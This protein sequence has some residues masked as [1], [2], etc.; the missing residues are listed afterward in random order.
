MPGDQPLAVAISINFAPNRIFFRSESHGNPPVWLD[1]QDRV[2]SAHDLRWT[3]DGQFLLFTWKLPGK[4]EIYALPIAERGNSWTKL[5]N[6]LG[7]KEP[8]PSPDGQYII[9][10]STRD[11]DP[12][13]YR[14]TITGAEQINLTNRVGRDLNP[15]WQPLP[16][17]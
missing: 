14:M 4:F 5:T 2:M 8:A 16:A 15:D 11:Q 10:T 3:P 6:S 12:E 7:N 1:V 17:D 13:I 9:F